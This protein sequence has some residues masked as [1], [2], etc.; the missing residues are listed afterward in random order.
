MYKRQFIIY[1]F[2]YYNEK[3]LYTRLYFI[4]LS[5]LPINFTGAFWIIL[6]IKIIGIKITQKEKNIFRT[7]RV[8]IFFYFK[9]WL[10]FSVF[11]DHRQ[12]RDV[13]VALFVF[14]RSRDAYLRIYITHSPH[15]RMT[16]NTVIVEKCNFLLDPVFCF[17]LSRNVSSFL[18]RSVS[19][20]KQVSRTTF[21][22]SSSSSIRVDVFFVHV[23]ALK[24][25]CTRQQ[26]TL[27]RSISFSA[28]V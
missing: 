23:W 13:S 27:A 10:T 24:T 5:C 4:S 9:M 22:P 11:E 6:V 26:C 7:K 15:Q 25:G 21:L 3:S 14:L 12:F 16:S 17:T 2:I 8:T 19:K 18:P 1:L 20:G 28:L